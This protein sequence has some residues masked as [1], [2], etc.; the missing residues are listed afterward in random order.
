M[1]VDRNSLNYREG[2]QTSAALEIPA[3]CP[4]SFLLVTNK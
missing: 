1:T 2:A 3:P 4:M